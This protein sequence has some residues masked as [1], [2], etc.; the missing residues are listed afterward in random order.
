MWNIDSTKI[1]IDYKNIR[2]PEEKRPEQIVHQFINL[3]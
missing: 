3:K 2:S 1:Q